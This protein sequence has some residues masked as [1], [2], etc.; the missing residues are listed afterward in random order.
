[1]NFVSS[2]QGLGTKIKIFIMQS[3]AKIL[4]GLKLRLRLRL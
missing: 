4:K 3:K 2:R 1:M